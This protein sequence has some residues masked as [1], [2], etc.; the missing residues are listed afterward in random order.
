MLSRFNSGCGCDCCIVYRSEFC[1]H[2]YQSVFERK[3]FG[4]TEGHPSSMNLNGGTFDQVGVFVEDGVGHSD[5]VWEIRND[6]CGQNLNDCDDDIDPNGYSYS[7][8]HYLTPTTNLASTYLKTKVIANKF[9]W[10]MYTFWDTCDSNDG[11]YC[12]DSTEN[13]PVSNQKMVFIFD[14]VDPNNWV[15]IEVEYTPDFGVTPGQVQSIFK[16][17][18][19]QNTEGVLSD[20]TQETTLDLGVNNNRINV[21]IDI[22]V[23]NN[24]DCGNV[25]FVNMQFGSA[26]IS[27]DYTPKNGNYIA[28]V[29]SSHSGVVDTITCDSQQ[30]TIGA[31]FGIYNWVHQ[32]MESEQTGC[33]EL[34]ESAC[35]DCF[36]PLEMDVTIS[37]FADDDCDWCDGELD[38][39]FTLIYQGQ[40][41]ITY[42]P[43]S[44]SFYDRT[45]CE[46]EYYFSGYDTA[47]C[48]KAIPW[49]HGGNVDVSIVTMKLR[50]H[51]YEYLDT[52][53]V[54]N[55]ASDWRFEIILKHY[56]IGGYDEFSDEYLCNYQWRYVQN[57]GTEIAKNCNLTGSEEFEYYDAFNTEGEELLS[58]F[59]Y[60]CHFQNIQGQVYEADFDDWCETMG[61]VTVERG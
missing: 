20:L 34:P 17:K 25:D 22:F 32:Y 42:F 6:A 27:F 51:H 19:R 13:E 49:P 55:Y 33:A 59:G 16:A 2:W 23:D 7:S 44:G 30:Y 38:D 15:G 48:E 47:T 53:A 4:N 29:K 58:G 54:T 5:K 52:Q 1:K 10:W 12:W 37:G 35:C 18:G 61:S 50:V 9:N 28:L 60:G 39:T 21:G 26:E 14:Y 31:G 3:Y 11:S 46:W 43:P 8:S 57:H 41:D 40:R 56:G 36:I 24:S 45:W